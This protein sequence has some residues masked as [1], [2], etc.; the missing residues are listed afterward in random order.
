MPILAAPS[1]PQET[2][3]VMPSS[4]WF[5]ALSSFGA[6]SALVAL[7]RDHPAGIFRRSALTLSSVAIS[8]ALKRQLGGGEIVVELLDRLGADDDAH[9]ALALQEPGERDA[10]DRNVVR[11]GDRLHRVDDVVGALAV[12]RREIERERAA[13][14]CGP[15]PSRV[16]L[17]DSRPPASGLHTITPRPCPRPAARSRARDR[18]RRSC[19]RPARSRSARSRAARRC[20]APS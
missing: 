19:N 6:G 5:F 10:R 9:H 4:L 12:D 2:L 17:P 8:S 18:A 20:P 1:T 13:R 14:R 15:A 16:N 11:L 7:A 3:R